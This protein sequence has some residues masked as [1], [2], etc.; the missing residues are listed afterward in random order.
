LSAEVIKNRLRIFVVDT[1]HGIANAVTANT[2]PLDIEK[3]KAAGF[4]EYLAKPLDIE[5][6]V[7]T[8]N[9]YLV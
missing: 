2:M 8:I 6:F 3:A 9:H 1:G 5:K 7:A 4:A